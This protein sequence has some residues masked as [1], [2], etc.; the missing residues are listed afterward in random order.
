MERRVIDISWVTLWRVFFFILFVAVLFLARNIMLGL[1]LALVIS[2]GLEFVVNFLERRGLPRAVGVVL[3]FLLASVAAILIV[4]AII[5]LVIV[6]TNTAFLTLADLGAHAWW[7]SFFNLGTAESF[8]VF[9]AQ[10]S[11][12]FFGGN[13]SPFETFSSVLGGFAL[14]ASVI[15]SSFYLSLTRDGVERFIR[16]VLPA[17]YQ[18][19][20]LSI[21]RR[22]THRVGLWFRAQF[23]LG[24]VV[25]LLALG[26]LLL[27]GVRY[28]ALIALIAGILEIVPYIGPLIAGALGM[29]AAFLTSPS[30]ALWTLIVFLIIHQI[31][32]HI[33]VPF[34]VGRN[35]GL[36]PV[37]VIIALLIGLEV[38]GVLGMI[39]SVPATVV[40]Q[41]IIDEWSGKHEEFSTV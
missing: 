9:V 17:R 18:G 29:F 12:K 2:S 32:G 1:F 24:V 40:I 10:F 34:L 19:T 30:L 31:E 14:A 33:L 21:Y 25:G 41:E 16:A 15:V 3:I 4:Y 38:G 35:T 39:I 7:G 6:E 23:I 11:S 20:A 27:L 22:A 37:I 5:P 26:S 8:N 28:A 13:A 36:H